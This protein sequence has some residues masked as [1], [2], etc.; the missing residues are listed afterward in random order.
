MFRKALTLTAIILV[1]SV[2]NVQAEQISASWDGGGDERSWE[3]PYNW[4]PDIVPDNTASQQFFV[5]I[6]SNSIGVEK[7]EIQIFLGPGTPSPIVS[8]ID[9]FGTVE[10]AL[11]AQ[12]TMED[13]N[14]LTNHGH[15]EI[16]FVERNDITFNII[17]NVN[18]TGSTL[19]VEGDFGIEDGDLTNA[20]RATFIN[21][22][23]PV[24]VEN[25]I[26]NYGRIFCAE[27]GHLLAYN[28]FHN[29]G[30]I[31]IYGG[32][33]E[34]HQSFINDVNGV[35][36]GYGMIHSGTII[37]NR[38]L[39]KS[40]AGDLF[41]H[42]WIYPGTPAPEVS[43]ISNTGTL[44]NSPGTT[45]TIEVPI[46][47][48]NN[49]GTIEVNADGSVVF[50]CNLVNEPN[51]LIKLLGGTL[52]ATTITQSADATLEGFGNVAGDVI[53][54]DGGIVKLTGPTNIVGDV[55]IDPNA[56]LEI[57]DGTTLITGHTICNN[58]TIRMIGGRIICQGGLTN[59]NCNI[60]WEPGTYTN[61][62]DFNLDGTVNF[63]DFAD[64]AD[65]WLWQAS[66][67]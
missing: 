13:A 36:K 14:G 65:T 47:D 61:V 31:S 53:V 46:P 62:A 24:D 66:W 18:N 50:D 4:D 43:G 40:F 27:A 8:Q 16:R 54:E 25:N 35:I 29:D 19:I 17:G 67:Y 55:T 5:T 12:L 9:C 51:G 48:V 39:I 49:E 37:E 30:L 59:N 64:F 7:I 34:S 52:A 23:Y 58:G 6:D 63:K 42:T 22:T 20:P 33:S 2:C 41:L 11:W 45:L 3:D 38:G 32:I 28:E 56:I 60:I 44:A 1:F 10:I 15:L 21:G 26:Y 57:S